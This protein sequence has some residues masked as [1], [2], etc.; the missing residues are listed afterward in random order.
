VTRYFE[1]APPEVLNVALEQL[2]AFI[3]N[4][5]DPMPYLQTIQ[6]AADAYWADQE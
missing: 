3:A 2:G 4:P 1:A 6:D 5:G